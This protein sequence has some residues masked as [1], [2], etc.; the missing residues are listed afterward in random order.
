MTTNPDRAMRLAARTRDLGGPPEPGGAD[1]GSFDVPPGIVD[2]VRSAL[3]GGETH[4]T[5]RPGTP[6]LRA[7]VARAIARLGG[8]SY[9]PGTSVVITAGERESLFVVL[10]GVRA[11]P[12]NVLVVPSPVPLYESLFAL[13]RLSPLSMERAGDPARP[14]GLLY[15]EWDADRDTHAAALERATSRGVIDALN[16]KD[17]IARAPGRALPALTSDRTIVIGG[18]EALAGGRAFGAGFIAGPPA[19]MDR[20]RTWKQAFSICTAA[21]SQR[22]A[23]AALEFR[24]KEG[25]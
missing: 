5:S 22:A 7:L 24:E 2:V 18:L 10:L 20:I 19:L 3:L 9:D 13:M 16:V 8:P 1:L 17:A 14:V 21:P 12:G 25:Q 23:I 6:A 15:R 11:G 4:Y